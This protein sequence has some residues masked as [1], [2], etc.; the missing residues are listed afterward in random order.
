MGYLITIEGADG[1]GKSS[2][3]SAIKTY[4]EEKGID[5]L[6]SREPGGVRISEAIRN[7][8]LTSAYPEMDA[9]T[10]ALLFAAARRQHFVEKILPAMEADRIMVL[11]RFLD[12]S[13]AYQGY[14]RGIG[15]DRV[16][17]I[18]DFALEGY[19]PDLTIL[20]DM[21]IDSA[22]ERI[23]R[24]PLREVNKLDREK[25]EFYIKVREGF[26]SIARSL[27]NRERVYTVDASKAPEEVAESVIRI[28]DEKMGGRCE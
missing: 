22:L 23:S 6:T 18:N 9:R 26:L 28:L 20:L 27:D 14:A 8:L 10:E 11:D 24:N 5:I 4:F 1:T 21:D 15:A 19:R 2:V 25:R 3:I 17:E 16:Q 7:L 12:S 13:I